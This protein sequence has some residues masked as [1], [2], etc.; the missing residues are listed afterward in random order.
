MAITN[1]E[2]YKKF[3]AREFIDKKTIDYAANYIALQ[4]N[5]PGF[6]YRF[7]YDM[8]SYLTKCRIVLQKFEK[9]RFGQAICNGELVDFI[10]D[11]KHKNCSCSSV[12][13]NAVL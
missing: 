1:F 11:E 6:N 9:T 10:E 2:A 4:L 7:Y 13:Y 12:Y 3:E 8:Y 5:S